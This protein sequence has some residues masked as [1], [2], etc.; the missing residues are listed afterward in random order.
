M[1]ELR[2][3]ILPL[4]LSQRRDWMNSEMD[5]LT[6]PIALAASMSTASASA[7][8]A[9]SGGGSA[10]AASATSAPTQ[11]G[12]LSSTHA[13]H[14]LWRDPTQLRTMRD[15]AQR[16]ARLRIGREKVAAAAAATAAAAASSAPSAAVRAE[17]P[18]GGSTTSHMVRR[19]HRH[20]AEQQRS[21]TANVAAATRRLCNVSTST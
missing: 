2:A 18:T 21:G 6:F 20:S 4:R 17:S 1:V 13:Q 11:C 10:P 5:R 7:A 3:F 16:R 15:V 19:P 12:F 8:A 9:A 14:W